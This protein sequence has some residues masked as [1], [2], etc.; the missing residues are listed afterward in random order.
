MKKLMVAVAVAGA[1]A[2]GAGAAIV[3]TA[4]AFNPGANPL[5]TSDDLLYGKMPTSISGDH[6]GE[7]QCNTDGSVVTDGIADNRKDVDGG[8]PKHVFSI[9]NSVTFVYSLGDNATGYDLT[10]YTAHFGW[11]DSGRAGAYTK[12]FY[13]ATVADPDVWVKVPIESSRG[14]GG[15][16]DWVK[17]SFNDESAIKYAAKVKIVVG[18]SSYGGL[19]ELVVR[20]KASPAVPY[21]VADDY[22]LRNPTTDSDAFVNSATVNVTAVPQ[23][24]GVDFWQTT[25]GGDRSDVDESA[26]VAAV[27]TEQAFT[28]T[29]DDQDIAGYVWM[30]NSTDSGYICRRSQSQTVRYTKTPPV[31][32]AKDVASD[33]FMGRTVTLT[34]AMADNGTT[35]GVSAGDGVESL[36]IP[37]HGFQLEILSGPGADTDSAADTLTVGV[38]GEYSVRFTAINK[39]GNTASKDIVWTVSE[40]EAGE[41]AWTGAISTDWN[42]GGNWYPTLVPDAGDQVKVPANTANTLTLEPTEYPANGALKSFTVDEGATVVCLGDT[43]AVNEEAGGTAAKPYGRGAVLSAATFVIAGTISAD[44][45]GFPSGK[46]PGV[47]ADG[48]AAHGGAGYSPSFVNGPQQG[49]GMTYGRFDAPTELGTGGNGKAG[50]G[51]IKLVATGDVTVNGAVTANATSGGRG[52]GGS[53]WI[54]AGGAF[55]GSGV[56]RANGVANSGTAGGGGRIR[57]DYETSTFSGRVEARGGDISNLGA[58]GTLYEEKRFPVGT[59]AVPADVTVTNEF[60]YVFPDDGLVRHWNL[61]INGTRQVEFHAGRLILHDFSI[62][63]NA[64][65][66]FSKWHSRA[67]A[68]MKEFDFVSKSFSLGG[69]AYVL[70]PGAK[71]LP[72]L[73]V[74]VLSVSA[75]TSLVFGRGDTEFVNEDAGGTAKIPLGKGSEIVCR[76]ATIAGTLSV[77]AQGFGPGFNPDGAD[78]GTAHGGATPGSG[79]W[80]AGYGH[81]TRPTELGGCRADDGSYFGGGAI[82][83]RVS[84][85]LNL[86]GVINADANGRGSGGSIW[87]QANKLTGAGTLTA[88]PGTS[89]RYGG[90][91]RI[92]VEAASWGFTGAMNVDGGYGRQDNASFPGTVFTNVVTA[93]A[94]FGW[95]EA[96]PALKSSY[97]KEV[98]NSSVMSYAPG[99]FGGQAFT[100]ARQVSDWVPGRKFAW[101]EG[102]SL[103]K[104]GAAVANTATYVL[105]NLTPNAKALITVDGVTTS[106]RVDADGKL[107]FSAAIAAGGTDVEVR[108]SNGMVLIVK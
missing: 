55:S 20:G 33:M 108:F 34:A 27:P 15:F 57:L 84:G 32:A 7:E 103:K 39:A 87:I 106:Q 19:L 107:T 98:C 64:R 92:A 74:D 1:M 23:I 30:T 77:A 42:E 9:G 38:A 45:Q 48:A 104:S 41:I 28:I 63:G 18:H 101:T 58:A 79:I 82:K 16:N 44:G 76:D 102:F 17:Y 26:W 72:V 35:G 10:S 12:E 49:A 105:D 22:T 2:F 85:E 62:G 69:T 89:T 95:D 8:Y 67:E 4:G 73:N 51:A 3:K 6:I 40:I 94:A 53:V 11:N 93:V 86:A 59:A 71:S 97:T 54:A 70:L 60:S 29:A 99:N 5:D 81:F 56:I 96:A 46:G 75:G 13:Y 14:G 47:S 24:G 50:G 65:V 78:N 21:L 66:A 91:G 43:T 52:S 80:K 61:T 37:L 83:M 25:E 31:A 88:K 100:L 36:E 68:D 90:G